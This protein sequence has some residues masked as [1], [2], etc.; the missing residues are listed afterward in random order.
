MIRIMLANL[1]KRLLTIRGYKEIPQQVTRP[2]PCTDPHK[3]AIMQA[4][5]SAFAEKMNGP[6]PDPLERRIRSFIREA[7]LMV[8]R[9]F[10]EAGL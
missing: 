1:R 5:I 10:Y 2:V 7:E 4:R 3:H 8:D 6:R 9:A